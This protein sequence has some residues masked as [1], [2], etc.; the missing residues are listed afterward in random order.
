MEVPKGYPMNNCEEGWKCKTI[1]V[2]LLVLLCVVWAKCATTSGS[3][4]ENSLGVPMFQDNPYTYKAGTVIDVIGIKNGKG[5]V[6]R[7][8]PTRTYALFTEDILFCDFP[9]DMF[10]GMMNPILL[11]YK[12][13]DSRSID[14]IGCHELVQVDQIKS[15]ELP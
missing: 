15:K 8:Q 2:I 13:Q 4:H 1:V 3:K 9:I 6:I 10:Q 11:T 14:G 5:M 12:T 7:L